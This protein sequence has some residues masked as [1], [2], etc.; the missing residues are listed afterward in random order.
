MVSSLYVIP[1]NAE[2]YNIIFNWMDL[3]YENSRNP[4]TLKSNDMRF[5]DNKLKDFACR[6]YSIGESWRL[7]CTN[8]GKTYSGNYRITMGFSNENMLEVVEIIAVHRTLSDCYAK[9]GSIE[10]LLNG[11]PYTLRSKFASRIST[12]NPVINEFVN[13]W[14]I[15]NVETYDSFKAADSGIAFGFLEDKLVLNFS[16]KKYFDKHHKLLYL[17]EN[18]NK[19]QCSDDQ[20]ITF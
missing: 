6:A 14:L 15:D 19:V 3:F 18:G 7:T 9:Y 8:K 12:K 5:L 1:A 20:C 17:D 4:W 13:P 2:S 16:S 11:I 10:Y